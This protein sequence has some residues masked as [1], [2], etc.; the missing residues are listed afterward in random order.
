MG[1]ATRQLETATV[2]SGVKLPIPIRSRYD[3]WIGGEYT[4]P[5][6]GQY[7]VNPTPVTGQP[8]CEVARSTHEDVD[9][10]SLRGSTRSGK[11][12]SARRP[13]T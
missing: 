2:P 11:R 4:A 12:S 13:V 6:R 10:A 9:K 7:F 1:T 5:A 3:N 8:L